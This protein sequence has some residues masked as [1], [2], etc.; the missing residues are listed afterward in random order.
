MSLLFARFFAINAILLV[1]LSRQSRLRLFGVFAG[2]AVNPLFVF[3]LFSIL[4]N[5]D[6]IVVWNNPEINF[7]FL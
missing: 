5:L 4:F 2:S 6:F 3:C 7:L 1:F